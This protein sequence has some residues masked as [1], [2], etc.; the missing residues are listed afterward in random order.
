M[1]FEVSDVR[2]TTLM[3]VKTIAARM[4]V[5]VREAGRRS[6][7]LRGLSLKSRELAY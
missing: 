3:T 5:G 4:A 2:V 7:D 1:G 6:D